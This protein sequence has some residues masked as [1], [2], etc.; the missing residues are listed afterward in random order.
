M[1][2]L[3]VF[4]STR[5]YKCYSALDLLERDTALSKSRLDINSH[6]LLLYGSNATYVRAL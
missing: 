4:S 1:R 2:R 6:Y 3:A 5:Q